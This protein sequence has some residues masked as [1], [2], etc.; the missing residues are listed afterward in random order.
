MSRFDIGSLKS[1]FQVIFHQ[2]LLKIYFYNFPFIITKWKV[3]FYMYQ[4]E[5]TKSKS[6]IYFC[7][8]DQYEWGKHPHPLCSKFWYTLI[9]IWALMT[10]KLGQNQR[11]FNFTP[12]STIRPNNRAKKTRK[13]SKS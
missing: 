10:R 9:T 2:K 1:S 7:S 6:L 3:G 8:W 4:K 5:V 12:N 11:P 13:L